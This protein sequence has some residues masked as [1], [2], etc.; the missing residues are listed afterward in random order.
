[1]SKLVSIVA[2]FYNEQDAVEAFYLTLRGVLDSLAA[3]RFEV[4]CVDDGSRDETLPKLISL[5]DRD[6]RARA[7]CP[8]SRRGC[9]RPHR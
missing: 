1:M 6:L 7:V 4:I 8:R 2:P 9:R 5:V 3:I